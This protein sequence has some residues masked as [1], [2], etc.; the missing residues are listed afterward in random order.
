M[1]SEYVY[2]RMRLWD[3][4]LRYCIYISMEAS[5]WSKQV[6]REGDGTKA[7]KYQEVNLTFGLRYS[8]D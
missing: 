8:P 2:G 1:E 3:S 5:T 4:I 6:L 7:Q